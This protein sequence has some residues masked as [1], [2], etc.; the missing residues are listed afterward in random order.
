MRPPLLGWVLVI[1]GALA[2]LG[3]CWATLYGVSTMKVAGRLAQISDSLNRGRWVQLR[4]GDTV[5]TVIRGGTYRWKR[6]Q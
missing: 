5:V 1:Y 3:V 4:Q 6:A 2:T